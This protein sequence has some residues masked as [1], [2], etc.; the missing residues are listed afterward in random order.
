MQGSLFWK[1][2]NYQ[3]TLTE[4]LVILGVPAGA[5]ECVRVEHSDVIGAAKLITG[6]L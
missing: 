1:G 5:I 6:G 2:P 3:E 4:T